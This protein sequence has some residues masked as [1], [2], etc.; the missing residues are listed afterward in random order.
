MSQE[1]KN[2]NLLLGGAALLGVLA[3]VGGIYYMNQDS[4]DYESDDD[5]DYR[6]DRMYRRPSMTSEYFC[7][8]GNSTTTE[9]AVSEPYV[10]NTQP[11]QPTITQESFPTSNVV[12][13]QPQEHYQQKTENF[14]ASPL[15]F[16]EMAGGY[17]SKEN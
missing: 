14:S 17:S 2:D 10:A 11:K 6:R 7:N 9:P 8:P 16:S 5:S 15:G 13:S 4:C 1:K 3:V 12:V